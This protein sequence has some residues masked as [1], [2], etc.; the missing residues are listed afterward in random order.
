M[1]DP[2][3]SLS[4]MQSTQAKQRKRE[5]KRL[6]REEKRR[7]LATPLPGLPLPPWPEMSATFANYAQPIIEQLPPGDAPG[8]L[9]RAL[10]IASGVWNAM[11]AERG[12]VDRAVDFV[13]RILTEETKQPVPDGLSAAIERLAVRKL[14]RF[15]DDHR[16]VTDVQV[17]RVGD[18]FRI[19]ASS[20]SPP[21]AVRLALWRRRHEQLDDDWPS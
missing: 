10:L 17:H 19:R 13:I 6:K 9:R 21:P 1:S 7:Q 14:A 11:V 16:I 2:S 5:R 3:A 20:E 15:D 12:D 18:E 4:P 8:Q